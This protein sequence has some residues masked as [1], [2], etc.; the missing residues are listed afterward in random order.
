MR[1][2]TT[3]EAARLMSVSEHAVWSLARQGLIPPG[4]VVRIGRRLRFNEPRLVEWLEAGGQGLPG[5]WRWEPE[6]E[7]R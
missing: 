3:A 7:V 6:A 5:G 2:I 4:V 1:L